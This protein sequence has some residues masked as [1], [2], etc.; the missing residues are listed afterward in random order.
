MSIYTTDPRKIDTDNDRLNDGDEVKRVKTNPLQPDTDGD[1]VLTALAATLLHRS[2]ALLRELGEHDLL[3]PARHPT[4]PGD[5][6]ERRRE[7][8]RAAAARTLVVH[9]EDVALEP[10]QVVPLVAAREVLEAHLV[11]HE[12]SGLKVL[13]APLRPDEADLVKNDGKYLYITANGAL[14]ILKAWPA[15]STPAA[16]RASRRT[17]TS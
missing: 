11:T 12:A 2:A 17:S 4:D 14:H 6:V 7:R 13:T 5:A 8:A 3:E 1:Q 10:D 9:L 16:T 15:D